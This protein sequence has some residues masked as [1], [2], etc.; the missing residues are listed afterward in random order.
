[1]ARVGAHSSESPG[2]MLEPVGPDHVLRLA[3]EI[4]IASAKHLHL[5]FVEHLTVSQSKVVIVDLSAVSFM[6]CAGLGALVGESRL[7]MGQGRQLRLLAISAPVERLFAVFGDCGLSKA[8]FGKSAEGLHDHAI[9]DKQI[10]LL[11]NDEMGHAKDLQRGQRDRAVVKQAQGLLMG[12]HGCGSDEAGAMLVGFSR[13]HDVDIQDLA[14]GVVEFSNARRAH[15]TASDFDPSMGE[16]VGALLEP[17][18]QG[19]SADSDEDSS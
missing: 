4:D 7:L 10:V 11:G 13:R 17:V 14:A 3:G 18:G 1:M 15:S 5:Q 8:D 2:V 19:T 12:I 16:A 9:P 6:D